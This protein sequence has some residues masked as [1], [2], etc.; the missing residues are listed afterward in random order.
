MEEEG[1]AFTVTPPDTDL[2]SSLSV[3]TEKY[4]HVNENF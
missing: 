1:F 2:L 3:L 4:D